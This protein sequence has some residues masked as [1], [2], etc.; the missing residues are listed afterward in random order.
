[1]IDLRYLLL[2]LGQAVLVL[3]LAVV[4]TVVAPSSSRHSARS[5]SMNIAMASSV[6]GRLAAMRR[7]SPSSTRTGTRQL[8]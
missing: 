4:A 8:G 7:G 3:L 2:R 1:M 5:S 6:C